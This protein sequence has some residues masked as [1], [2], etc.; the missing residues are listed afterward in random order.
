MFATSVN[1]KCPT[2]QFLSNFHPYPIFILFQITSKLCMY[3][4]FKLRWL[5]LQEWWIF[6]HFYP[7]QAAFNFTI[8][9]MIW[10]YASMS[11]FFILKVN[12]QINQTNLTVATS[13]PRMRSMQMTNL[14]N[15]THISTLRKLPRVFSFNN[16]HKIVMPSSVWMYQILLFFKQMFENSHPTPDWTN[17]KW[18]K[19]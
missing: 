18:V 19:S 11:L 15:Q 16:S 8:L 9:H 4:L 6:P 1:D 14:Y 13:S 10:Y 7:P 2:P 5:L 12:V 3:F 17:L